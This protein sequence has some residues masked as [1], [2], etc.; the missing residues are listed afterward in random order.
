MS[1]LKVSKYDCEK[2]F[3]KLQGL[4]NKLK[5]KELKADYN[6]SLKIIELKL[7]KLIK[8]YPIKT[9]KNNDFYILNYQMEKHIQKINKVL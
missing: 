3:T 4:I 7:Q 8:K 9:T 6:K 2:T 5:S 1:T